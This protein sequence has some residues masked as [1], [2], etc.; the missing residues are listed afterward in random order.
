MN[1]KEMVSRKFFSITQGLLLL[2]VSIGF[3]S[4]AGAAK[5]YIVTFNSPLTFQALKQA[6]RGE[7]IQSKA[8]QMFTNSGAKVEQVLDHIQ[9]VVVEAEGTLEGLKGQYGIEG[10]EE[11]VIIPAPQPVSMPI[12]PSGPPPVQEK[13]EMPWGIE[14]IRA[15]EAWVIS[16]KGQGT[17]VLVLDTGIDK[18]HPNL[19]SR[20]E[21][22]RNFAL[23]DLNAPYPYFDG[24]SHGTHVAGTI[25]ADG[26]GSGLYG[27][28][29]RA[30]ILAGRVCS[31]LGCTSVA[32]TGGLDW[33]IQEKVDAVNM[34][35]GSAFSSSAIAQAIR[36]VTSAG[37]VVVAAS[38]NSGTSNVSY[39]AAYSSTI[40]VGAVNEKLTKTEFS[41]WGPELDIMA[42]GDSITSS[43][44]QGSGR[45][46]TVAFDIDGDGNDW[47]PVKSLPVVGSAV[48]DHPVVGE[49]VF[50]QLGKPEHFTN[51]DV[52]DKIALIQR[53][54]I[55]FSDKI[56]NAIDAGAKGVI[57][58][59]NEPGLVAASL[60]KEVNVPVAFIAQDVGEEMVAK[61][62]VVA[63][64]FSRT[65]DF[66]KMSGTSMAAPHLTGVV[67]LIKS[68]NPNL[69]PAQIKDLIKSTAH[70]QSPNDEN[71]YGAGLV[72]SFKAVKKAIKMN[73]PLLAATGTDN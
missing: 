61:P 41:Q 34:S 52:K 64:I 16:Q 29:P 66:Q 40:A 13:V 5:K 62:K 39:P 33:A 73:T 23:E 37:I 10:I 63:R 7:A 42:P 17:R 12:G 19:V 70:K 68:V 58:Y 60:S 2:A 9:M 49:T 59:N 67:A 44:P 27:V 43:V 55:F 72:D 50:C 4:G 18:D 51:I 24:I 71:Q 53:G 22:A 65:S 36:T 30:K 6:H 31:S 15:P 11:E 45:A 3:I 38:G 46:I 35:L 20:F 69:D 21:K 14:A 8:F 26:V 28:A 56:K 1:S 48:D 47:I 57:L 32:I 54:E 25:A